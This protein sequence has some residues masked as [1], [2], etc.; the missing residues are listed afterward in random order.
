[1]CIG[2]GLRDDGGDDAAGDDRAA[3]SLHPAPDAVWL[4]RFPFQRYAA[5]EEGVD[6][7]GAQAHKQ[8]RG[9]AGC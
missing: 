3:V 8:C 9:S 4:R 6:D 1:V 5:G 7:A 2:G